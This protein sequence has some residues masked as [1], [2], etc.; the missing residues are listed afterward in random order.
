MQMQSYMYVR[1]R[2]FVCVRLHAHDHRITGC[3]NAIQN[4]IAIVH[5]MAGMRGMH[6]LFVLFGI[7]TLR[8]SSLD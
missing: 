3:Q 5:A 8:E 7:Q 2:E 1:M 4:A 6:K